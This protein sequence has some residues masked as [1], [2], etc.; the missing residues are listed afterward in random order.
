MDYET[1]AANTLQAAKR[2]RHRAYQLQGLAFCL[3]RDRNMGRVLETEQV[4]I[5]A[6]DE[7]SPKLFMIQEMLRENEEA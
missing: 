7:L 4:I 6:L 2:L 1:I 3:R 5:D